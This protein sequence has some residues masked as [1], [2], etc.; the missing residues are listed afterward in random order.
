MKAAENTKTPGLGILKAVIL[1][2]VL[3]ALGLTIGVPLIV[4]Y[5]EYDTWRENP[6]QSAT[7]AF[8]WL[9]LGCFFWLLLIGLYIHN[10][11]LSQFRKKR[12]LSKL[13]QNGRHTKGTIISKQ[14]VQSMGEGL[15]LLLKVEFKNF[16]NALVETALDIVDSEPAL[17]RFATGKSIALVVN[18]EIS[19]PPV[20]IEGKGFQW[21]RTIMAIIF[22]ILLLMLV[23]APGLLVY[24]YIHESGGY[25]WRYLSF[26]H[27]F[28]LI[29][30][31]GLLE[32]LPFMLFTGKPGKR[33]T[34]SRLLLYGKS[35]TAT[36]IHT[37]QTGLYINEQPQVLFTVEFEGARGHTT[38]ASFKKVVDL[39]KI[40]DITP[41]KT[42]TVLYNPDNPQQIAPVE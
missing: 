23:L 22:S 14:V 21:N 26:G 6:G 24:S 35:A 16:S 8:F 4:H 19:N 15:L 29:P 38:H 11:I 34:A 27:P 40:P 31:I 20:I 12:Q 5:V 42:I 25:G 32:L 41:G 7:M 17:D 39:L 36:I 2:I 30:F 37:Q 10:F 13:M 3:L 33:S 1:I 18:P 28:I 9:G